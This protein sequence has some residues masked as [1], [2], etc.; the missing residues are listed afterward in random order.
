LGERVQE[1]GELSEAAMKRTEMAL[2]SLLWQAKL[3]EAEEVRIFGTSA[4][5]VARN[6]ADFARRVDRRLHH[7]IRV[8]THLEEAGYIFRG[9]CSEASLNADRLL[10]MDL[11]GG[12]AEWVLGRS[13]SIQARTGRNIG[14]VW[15]TEAYL[16][17]QP[18]KV[19][20]RKALAAH[21]RPEI[22]SALADMPAPGAR[23]VFT[24]GTACAVASVAVGRPWKQAAVDGLCPLPQKDLRR[25]VNELCK[26]T[27]E[28]LLSHPLI[29]AKRAGVVVAG[30]ITLLE[31]LLVM[32]AETATVSARGL[33][34]GL[35]ADAP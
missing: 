31:S 7:P 28:T 11:G 1:T 23:M 32:E 26:M 8:L 35:A 19:A 30:A 14:C 4:F 22:E 13:G 16:T 27:R 17:G 5:R 12:S 24:G 10:V 21:V 15:M 29:P 6:A 9:V 33:R 25:V 18:I 34:F 20:E 3:C 2:E